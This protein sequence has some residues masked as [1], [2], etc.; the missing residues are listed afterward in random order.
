MVFPRQRL[1]C[2]AALLLPLAGCGKKGPPLAPLARVPGQVAELTAARSGDAVHLT[3]LVPVANVGGD[4]PADISSVEIYAVTAEREPVVGEREP[5]PEW[6]LVHRLPVRR[7]VP[8][9]PPTPAGVPPVPPLPIEPG[10]DQG[11]RVTIHETLT[12][13]LLEPVEVAA[14]VPVAAADT[15]PDAGRPALA[16]PLVAP[17]SDRTAR[18]FYAARA[19]ARRGRAGQWSA[20]RSVPTASPIAA[21]VVAAPTYDAAAV[22]ITWAPPPGA[23]VAPP[24]PAEGGLPSRPFGPATPATTYNVYAAAADPA[25]DALGL[26]T[27]PAPLNPAPIEAATFT[28]SG[29]TF[30][31]ERC[32]V[33]RTLTSVGGVTIESPASSPVCVTPQDT[34]APPAPTA[35]EAVGGAGVISLIWEAVE[36]PD[37]AGYLVFRGENG[38]EPSTPLTPAPI[39]DSSFEDRG[40]TP[41]VRYSYVVVAVDSATPANRS[42]PSNRAEETARQ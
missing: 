3:V 39:R 4:S 15:E 7:P 24:P 22:T 21:P 6:T 11:Q 8:P 33:V 20:I 40:V 41:G 13:D 23:T 5:G 37:L 1:M 29:V 42:A 10:V 38:A 19:V 16:L 14:A 9:A 32:F 31:E 35:L 2:A 30:G 25:P 17:A 12:A 28:V 36:T 27:R 34:F 18:R 26:V